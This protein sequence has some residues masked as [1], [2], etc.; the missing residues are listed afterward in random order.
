MLLTYTYPGNAARILPENV[1]R[2]RDQLSQF[3]GRPVLINFWPVGVCL[4]PGNAELKRVYEARKI[5]GFVV[6][7]VNVTYQDSLQDVQR[8][9]AEFGLTF[10]VL[11][12]E[13]ARWRITVLRA[14]L[15]NQYFCG[16]GGLVAKIQLGSMTGAQ[17]D[18]F[19]RNL[20]E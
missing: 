10:P 9:V 18:Q 13:P 20:K 12:D 16:S 8:F 17:L 3:R 7:A 14:R 6:L 4:P 15:T 5:D 11:L 19:W 1:R 2:Q